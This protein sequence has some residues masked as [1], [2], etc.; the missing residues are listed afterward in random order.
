MMTVFV[1][2]DDNGKIVGIYGYPCL[3]VAEEELPRDNAEVVAFLASLGE[4]V[5]V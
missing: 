4:F 2:R 5:P 1:E 3:G